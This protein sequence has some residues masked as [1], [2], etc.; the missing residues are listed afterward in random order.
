MKHGIAFR[1]LSRTTSH[2]MLML[3]N[4]VTSLFEHEQIKTTLPKARETARLAEKIITLGKKGDQVSHARAA[5]LL[6]KPE[7]LLKLFGPFAQRYAQRPGGYTRIHKFGNRPGDNAP[8]AVL[9]LVD[10]PRDI[11]WEMTS[12][13]VGWDLL[14]EKLKSKRPVSII[15]AGAEDALDVISAER[16][17]TFGQSGLLRPKTR[18]N[19]QKVLRFRDQSAPLLLSQK[20]GD[21][22]A[23]LLEERD[24]AA[25]RRRLIEEE[26]KKPVQERA[27]GA[28]EAPP[29][30]P[31]RQ[32]RPA[33]HAFPGETRGALHLARGFLGD[34]KP[35]AKPKVL[36]RTS[37]FSRQ[38]Q[39]KTNA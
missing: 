15:N 37:L 29:E 25:I 34:R 12:R 24:E 10:N 23:R 11:R 5:A 32:M 2:R 20:S 22:M 31:R 38:R 18:W 9:E 8:H 3:R 26:R 36:S 6:L 27:A 16:R 33:G 35:K 28:D 39:A 30:T 19:L 13:A 21:Y 4:L 14:R 17:L 7:L 1:K